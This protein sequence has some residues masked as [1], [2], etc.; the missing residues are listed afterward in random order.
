MT[1]IIGDHRKAFWDEFGFLVLPGFFDEEEIRTVEEIYDRVWLTLPSTVVVDDLDTGRRA[2]LRDIGAVARHDRF[3]VNDL[4]LTEPR[5][6]D[7]VLS[8]RIGMVVGELLGDEPTICNSLNFA[9]GSQQPDHLDTLYMPGRH[10]GGLVATWMALEDATDDSGPLRYYP[11]SNHIEPYR[12]STGSLRICPEEMP[13][14]CDYMA[15]QVERRGLSDTRFLARR[16][17]L[18]I[19]SELLLHGGCE[20]KD[21]TSTRRSVV[22]HYWRL[23]ECE[24]IHLDLRPCAGGWW[25]SRPRLA[26]SDQRSAVAT[27]VGEGV[28]DIPGTLAAGAA[29]EPDLRDRLAGLDV[30]D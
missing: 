23:S 1:S 15:E 9:K 7:V 2:L 13:I 20:I 25:I 11:E 22:T 27:T 24:E 29:A 10:D 5:L 8:E 3:K 19:W 14:W 16:G 6:R 28:A 26:V 12:F 21:L 4:Y 18:F 30:V 17:D